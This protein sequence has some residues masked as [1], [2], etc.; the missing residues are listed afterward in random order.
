MESYA[1][2]TDGSVIKEHWSSVFWD[3]ESLNASTARELGLMQAKTLQRHLEDEFKEM[4]VQVICGEGYVLVKPSGT[5][6]GYM[7][8]CWLDLV[9]RHKGAPDF[10]FSCGD[11]VGDNVI[12]SS[13]AHHEFG[14]R[15][16]SM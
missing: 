3:Y 7:V 15:Q 9:K 14:A 12:F 11:A 5:N 2:R 6:N 13:L 10:I 1:A 8:N 16:P 4:P